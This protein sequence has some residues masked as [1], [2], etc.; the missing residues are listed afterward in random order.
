MLEII[1]KVLAAY[2]LGNILGGDVVGRFR[3]VDLRDEGSGNVGATNAMRS[4]GAS[5][6]ILVL[7]IDIGKAVLAV[8][9]L[10]ILPWYDGSSA[11]LA[12]QINES[13]WLP[14]LCGVAVILGHCYPFRY[15]FKG[16][17]GV[18]CMVGVVAV[19]AFEHFPWLILAWVII[20]ILTGYVSLASI[21]A[22]VLLLVLVLV[23]NFVTMETHIT[24]VG[25]EVRAVTQAS[26]EQGLNGMTSG[27]VNW[28]EIVF[29][30][31]LAIFIAFSHRA[32]IQRLFAGTESRFAKVM[33]LHRGLRLGPHKSTDK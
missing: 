25:E 24:L 4:Q 32:N 14:M 20:L 10:P 11:E 27:L 3:N 7:L 33:L 29:S 13:P 12:W 22:A 6:A 8:L 21:V 31:W 17:K 16:G 9:V 18:A 2:L 19:L 26:F 1:I 23:D 15:Q 5:F 30:A 28:A